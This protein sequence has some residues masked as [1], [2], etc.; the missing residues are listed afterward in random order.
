MG[1]SPN[2]GPFIWGAYDKDHS[3]LGCVLGPPILGKY[4]VGLRN[5]K[6]KVP[7]VRSLAQDLS[8][9]PTPG[10]QYNLPRPSN[11]VSFLILL[12]RVLTKKP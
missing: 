3:I 9:S 1:S 10:T 8:L 7:Q 11:V 6:I 2:D 5:H 4:H 12:I